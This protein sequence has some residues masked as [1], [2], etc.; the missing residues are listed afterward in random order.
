MP[1]RP[2]T[3]LMCSCE[4]TMLLDVDAVQRGCRGAHVSTAQQLCRAELERFGTVVS[5]GAA[6]TVAC[7]QEAPLFSEV[8]T[9]GADITFVNIR[10]TAGWSS[11]A[12]AVGPKMAA[13]LAV[14]SEP[15]PDYPF[16]TLSSKGVALIYGRDGN[17]IEA[18]TRLQDHLDVTVL[19]NRPDEVTP[20]RTM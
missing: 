2:R 10:E 20:P 1:D 13:L 18:A 4:N 12:E 6:V 17:A 11:D 19:I 9:K 8:A 7:V 5:E 3:I 15:M 14:A 16:V